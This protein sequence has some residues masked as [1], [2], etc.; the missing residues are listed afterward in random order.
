METKGGSELLFSGSCS[1]VFQ[2][3]ARKDA[4][5]KARDGNKKLEGAGEMA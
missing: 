2:D 5:T 4:Q 3:L 1:P